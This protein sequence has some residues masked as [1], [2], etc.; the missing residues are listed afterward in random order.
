MASPAQPPAIGGRRATGGR[1][2]KRMPCAVFAVLMVIA[3]LS[4]TLLAFTDIGRGLAGDRHLAVPVAQQETST[5]LPPPT[6]TLVPP[7]DFSLPSFCGTSQGAEQ[8]VGVPWPC[9]HRPK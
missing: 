8:A 5:P 6:P 7:P 3:V 2:G 9:T 1:R 4:G